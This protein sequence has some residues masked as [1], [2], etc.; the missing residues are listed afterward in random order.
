MMRSFSWLAAALTLALQLGCSG[1]QPSAPAAGPEEQASKAE[2]APRPQT[3]P[4]AP[5]R[6]EFAAD[7]QAYV[8][9][10][11]CGAFDKGDAG[12]ILAVDSESVEFN[13]VAELETCNFRQPGGR[14]VV[15][16]VHQADSIEAAEQGI[17]ELAAQYG[18]D[19]VDT[20][21]FG[22]HAFHCS[23]SPR[24]ILARR[25]RFYVEVLAPGDKSRQLEIARRVIR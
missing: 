11:P 8:A 22:L 2:A 17:R 14:A 6:I 15:Y 4:E 23:G 3:E 10:M 19:C 12:E 9:E 18:E 1:E 5:Q 24:A 13:Y 7:D 20:E 16:A 21:A 25:G